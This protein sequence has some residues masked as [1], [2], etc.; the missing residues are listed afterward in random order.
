MNHFSGEPDQGS[1]IR[2]VRYPRLAAWNRPFK[3]SRKPL[4]WRVCVEAALPSKGLRIARTTSCIG[5]TLER[6]TAGHY[7]VSMA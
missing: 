1:A 2:S 3:N 4:V 6:M 7:S 5:S